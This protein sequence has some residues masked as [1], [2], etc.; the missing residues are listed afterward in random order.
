[1]HV[2]LLWTGPFENIPF[3]EIEGMNLSDPSLVWMVR[4]IAMSDWGEFAL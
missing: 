4:S 3:G 2:F 1:M